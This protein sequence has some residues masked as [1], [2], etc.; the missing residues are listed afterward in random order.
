[1]AGTVFKYGNNVD[2]DV[3]LPARYL[4]LYKDEDLAAEAIFLTTICSVATIPLMV[5][6]LL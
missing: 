2:T 4:A 1:M 3:I 6:L 5:M